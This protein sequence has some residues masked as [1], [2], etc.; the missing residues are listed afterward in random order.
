[1]AFAAFAAVFRTSAASFCSSL[2]DD[3]VKLQEMSGARV[4][5]AV[6]KYVGLPTGR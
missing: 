6:G 1:L 4:C 2:L 3:M 5:P